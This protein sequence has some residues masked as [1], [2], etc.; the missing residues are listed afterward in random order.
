MLAGAANAVASAD[1]ADATA[2]LPAAW[3]AVCVISAAPSCSPSRRDPRL[4][5][6]FR[7]A[8][9]PLDDVADA[10]RAAPALRNAPSD[11]NPA[12]SPAD[13]LHGE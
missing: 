9:E 13:R 4:P 12:G 3:Q 8:G 1:P 6:A 10:L 7:L 5:G 11:V 2:F